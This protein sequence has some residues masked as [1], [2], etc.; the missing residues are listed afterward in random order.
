MVVCVQQL[1]FVI[2]APLVWTWAFLVYCMTRRV[3][4]LVEKKF[5]MG[6]ER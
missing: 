1:S 2:W 3:T 6:K 5:R 4:S